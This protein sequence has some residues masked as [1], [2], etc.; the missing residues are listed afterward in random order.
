MSL[1]RRGLVVLLAAASVL[2]SCDA[3]RAG[4]A[5]RASTSPL[6]C[7]TAVGETL[8]DVRIW[9]GIAADG[10]QDA[11]VRVVNLTPATANSTFLLSTGKDLVCGSKYSDQV[12]YSKVTTSDEDSLRAGDVLLGG[13]G[14]DSLQYVLGGYFRAGAD[15]DA[16]GAL[17]GGTF[18]GGAGNDSVNDG[19]PDG[20]YLGGDGDDLLFSMSGGA[21][22]GG[23]GTD[24]SYLYIA[25]VLKNVEQCTLLDDSA[26]P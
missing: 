9:L 1:H 8:T 4:T 13:G 22:D 16:V 26:C 5:V 24:G 2:A 7:A 10:S 20:I 21:F 17:N 23:V 6:A 3:S 15:N 25:G 14:N 19:M 12:D 11:T 18:D